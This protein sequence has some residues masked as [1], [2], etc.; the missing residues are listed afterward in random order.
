MDQD[1]HFSHCPIELKQPLPTRSK[2]LTTVKFAFSFSLALRF[3]G[4]GFYTYH[5]FRAS[6]A[7]LLKLHSGEHLIRSCIAS[8][9][10]PTPPELHLC[11]V[12]SHPAT[13]CTLTTSMPHT[14]APNKWKHCHFL[15]PACC[16]P[17]HHPSPLTSQHSVKPL[18]PPLKGVDKRG[19]PVLYQ[20][21]RM[22]CNN[23]ND[24]GYTVT[25]TDQAQP[26]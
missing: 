8:F 15:H 9:L 23:F 22:A 26:V 16:S 12:P 13:A 18:G 25:T 20:G 11:S 10:H 14:T 3:G 7:T 5:I 24:L 17:P 1:L 4:N 21:G 6:Q 19:R 2:E